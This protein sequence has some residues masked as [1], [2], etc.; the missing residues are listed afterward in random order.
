MHEVSAQPTQGQ[1]VQMW[2]DEGEV[3]S[4]T[5][6]IQDGVKEFLSQDPTSLHD[7]WFPVQGLYDE[8]HAE[9]ETYWVVF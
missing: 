6:R 1:W 4:M 8:V 7:T 9:N 5:L 3:W 2:I